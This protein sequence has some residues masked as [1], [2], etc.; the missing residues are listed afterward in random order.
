MMILPTARPAIPPSVSPAPPAPAPQSCLHHFFL[1]AC[2]AH[3]HQTFH[4]LPRTQR[5]RTTALRAASRRRR[6]WVGVEQVDGLRMCGVCVGR[7]CESFV[8]GGAR[9]GLPRHDATR[10][11][12]PYCRHTHA[13]A[14]VGN[15][16]GWA[17]AG[18]GVT[19][20]LG[21]EEGNVV[22]ERG[23][24]C[25][26]PCP[27]RAVVPGWRGDAGLCTS[28]PAGTYG[29]LARQG[30]TRKTIEWSFARR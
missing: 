6:A 15:P 18:G 27:C 7:V 29:R 23:C 17:G 28:Q 16:L 13:W 4:A 12:V 1:A 9:V 22:D 11:M 30:S 19:A 26:C 25:V 24:V 14:G 2:A 10:S 21:W 8:L 3:S 5:A 20:G